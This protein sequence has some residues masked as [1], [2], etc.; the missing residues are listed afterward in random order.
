M[1][2]EKVTQIN[3][4]IE[5]CYTV[6]YWHLFLLDIDDTLIRFKDEECPNMWFR[7]RFSKLNFRF[8]NGK[9]WSYNNLDY[10]RLIKEF[11]N[12]ISNKNLFSRPTF[13][14][15][16]ESY[17]F[18]DNIWG[19]TARGLEL[20]KTTEHLLRCHNIYFSVIKDHN[21]HYRKV[22]HNRG[23]SRSGVASKRILYCGGYDKGECLG[24]LFNNLI[25]IDDYTTIRFVDDSLYNLES[26][27][28]YLAEFH[29]NKHFI[30][31]H[32]VPGYNQTNID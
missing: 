7:D 32:Y 13:D 27:E 3:N 16:S 31:Y 4:I 6:P 20:Y 17:V 12:R 25:N 9:F 26:V 14:S 8:K 24:W 10:I 29:P 28:A 1:S 21:P 18:K 23:G 30:G 2:I 19:F 11:N 5:M 15:V 22:F